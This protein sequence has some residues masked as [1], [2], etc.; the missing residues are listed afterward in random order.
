VSALAV[1]GSTV[2]AAGVFNT[3]GGR[4]RNYIAALDATTG[5]ASTWNPNAGD[6]VL[7]M[8]VSESTVYAG[9]AFSSIGG[10]TRNNLAAL[11]AHTGVATAWN[12]NAAD[13]FVSALAASGSTVYAGGDFNRIGGQPRN[14]IAA[15][16]ATTGAATAWNPHTPAS[17]LHNSGVYALALSGAN[18]YAGGTF[19]SIGG[20]ARLGL[21]A[22]DS[23]T[24]AAT[25]GA[26]AF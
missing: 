17:K 7:A 11:D 15:I 18:V 1:S 16:D 24:G 23:R 3:I 14:Y 22:L 13:G 26:S 5:R 9:G 10:V 19:T 21:A 6:G 20:Q 2:Y 8:A 4:E 25:S 12:P